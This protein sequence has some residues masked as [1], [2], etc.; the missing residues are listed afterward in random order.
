M[1]QKK[2]KP[3]N[4]SKA[5]AELEKITRD[6][7]NGELDLEK[8]IPKF[9]RGLALAKLLKERLSKIENEIEEIKNEF[10]SL[11]KTETSNLNDL[12]TPF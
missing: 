3:I 12:E 7:E 8:A 10:K 2:Q 6:F 1:N 5:F 11:E 9:K 4:L